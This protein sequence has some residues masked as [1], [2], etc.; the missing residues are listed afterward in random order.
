MSKYQNF[1]SDFPHRCLELLDRAHGLASASGRE[2]TLLLMVA[3]ASLVV[4]FERLK[5]DTKYSSHPFGE[6]KRFLRAA[7]RLNELMSQKFI[8]S[9]LCPTTAS[10]WRLAKDV[11]AVEGDLD[12]WLP[13]AKLKALSKDREVAS[14]LTLVRNAL[15]HGSIHTIGDPITDLIFVKEVIG[16]HLDNSPRRIGFEVICVSYADFHDFVRAWI[17]FLS[18]SNVWGLRRAA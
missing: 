10:S 14:T 5:P 3:S 8:G 16:K 11:K 15:S 4:P 17:T 7:E 12:E 6:N 9:A 1:T 2:V 18:E 13:S